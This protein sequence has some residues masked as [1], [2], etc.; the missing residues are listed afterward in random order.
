M[1]HMYYKNNHTHN[2][3]WQ[4][5]IAISFL[6]ILPACGRPT[7]VTVPTAAVQSATT[8]TA[9]LKPTDLLPSEATPPAATGKSLAGRVVRGTSPAPGARVELR[10][11]DWRVDPSKNNVVASAVADANGQFVIENP[12][13]GEY[14]LCAVWP[15]GEEHQGAT[16][17]VNIAAGQSLTNLTVRLE[18]M[19]PVVEPKTGDDVSGMPH[20]A[21]KGFSGVVQYRV[22]VIDATTAEFVLDEI[23]TGTGL[24]LQTP[25]KAGRTYRWG[26][27]VY[28]QDKT[29]L[30]TFKSWFRIDLLTG[31]DSPCVETFERHELRQPYQK[32]NGQAR[33]TLSTRELQDTL[34][35]MGIRA[36]C[37]LPQ[38]GAPFINADWDSA[39]QPST[40]GR[41]ISL[42]FENLYHGSGWSEGFVVYST[43]DFATD[44][45]YETFAKPEDPR[46]MPGMFEGNGV[47]GFVRVKPSDLGLGTRKAYLT[48]VFPF[49]EDYVAVVYS[50]GDYDAGAD[51]K[52]IVQGLEGGAYPAD[53]REGAT[54]FDAIKSSIR[55]SR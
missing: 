38:L 6:L 40:K 4:I 22:W 28:A 5:A 35:V 8:A 27:S 51:W 31:A 2:T 25:L 19:L 17:V 13:V 14:S 18:M 10:K 1:P 15:N 37:I 41:M 11:V 12:P 49:Y 24:A 43:Y 48:Y 53:K 45:E 23:I 55:F 34:A 47:M 9:P 26:V 7:S 50:L 16:P 32:Y 20:L 42:G 33:Y 36:L 44:S 3:R 54:L 29:E 46:V 30:V 39:K 21:W 52:A